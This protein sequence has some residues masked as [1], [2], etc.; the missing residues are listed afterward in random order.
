MNGGTAVLDDRR[1]GY[2]QYGAYGHTFYRL[3]PVE[4]YLDTHPEYFSLV[5]GKRQGGN[6]SG[7]L[8]LT[9]PDVQGICTGKRC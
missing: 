8:C 2:F 3:L 6:D 4:K 7:Q 5:K 9:N 1:G